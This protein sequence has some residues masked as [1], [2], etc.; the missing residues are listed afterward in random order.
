MRKLIIQNSV[1]ERFK[2]GRVRWENDQIRP[3]LLDRPEVY[4]MAAEDG[5][6]S[7]L[8]K[9][10]PTEMGEVANPQCDLLRQSYR[11][12]RAQP[13]GPLSAVADRS[14]LLLELEEDGLVGTDQ[15]SAGEENADEGWTK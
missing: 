1:R 6:F 7:K 15:R 3:N 4:R 2:N 12:P 10:P 11:L 9:R 14:F 13:A 5:V 8:R